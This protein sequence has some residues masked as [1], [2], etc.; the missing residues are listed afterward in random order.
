V[1][2]RIIRLYKEEHLW[3]WYKY[4]T[5]CIQVYSAQFFFWKRLW[6]AKS[7]SKFGRR[8][9]VLVIPMP[10][11]E[12]GKGS[13]TA[14]VLPRKELPERRSCAFR[15]KH[16]PECINYCLT[17]YFNPIWVAMY[18]SQVTNHYMLNNVGDN[19]HPYRTS[20]ITFNVHLHCYLIL[21][22]LTYLC[23]FLSSATLTL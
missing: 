3:V 20:Q 11:K 9:V 18:Y 6:N 21:C 8:G 15:H 14:R 1:V 4:L 16:T 10:G 19:G 2:Y 22:S 13:G 17:I 23:I 12:E 7:D 5:I